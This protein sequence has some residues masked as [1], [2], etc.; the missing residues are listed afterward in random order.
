[1]LASPAILPPLR[2]QHLLALIGHTPLVRLE[3]STA[4]LPGIEIW[5]KLEFV[6]PGGS[7]K[8][9]PARN[10]ILDGERS[11]RLNPDKI[12]LDATSGNT[13]IAYAMIG[14]ARGYKVKLCLPANASEERKRI[15][16]VLGAEL[17]LT[18]PGEGSDGAFRKVRE[19]YAADPE[20]YFYADQYNNDANWKAHFHTTGPEI[21]EQ[22]HGRLTHFVALLGTTGTFT[23]TSRR[24][25]RDLPH[26]ECWSAQPATPFHGVEGTKHLP[27]S[28]VP[29]IYDEKVADGN[30]WIETEDAYAM[31]RK[32]AREEGLLLGISA[33]GN[34]VAARKLGQRL[35]R[36]GK[37]G[38]IVTIACDG[39]S[40]YLSDGFWNEND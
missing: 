38:V 20:R 3:Q 22:T 34:I 29:G 37:R 24:L 26:V 33:A 21:M 16:T 7:V 2:G 4:D 14:A 15:L 8:D 18:D 5:L 9:R 31:A 27:A 19:L 11:G 10:I 6:N 36:E 39:A 1:M 25:K 30:L 23:G 12:I 28:I 13:G 17:V 35:V 32:M 40:K